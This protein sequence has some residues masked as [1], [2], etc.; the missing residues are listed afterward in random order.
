MATPIAPTPTLRGDAARKFLE[1][2]SN[3]R[4]ASKEEIERIT[5]NAQWVRDRMKCKF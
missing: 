4:K 2:I 5:A 3:P 1:D